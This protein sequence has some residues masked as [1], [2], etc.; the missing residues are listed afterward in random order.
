MPPFNR[1]PDTPVGQKPL[2]FHV[3]NFGGMNQRSGGTRM[4][5]KD[6]QFF[7]QE[8]LWPIQ[9][10]NLESGL[11]DGATVFTTAKTIINAYFYT[12]NL[13]PFCIAFFSDGT[14]T[15]FHTVTGAQ[16]VVS[17][18]ANQF[19]MGSYVPVAVQWN[20]AGIIIAAA[21]IA[22]GYFAWDGTTLFLPGSAAPNWLT[23]TTPTTMP[24]GVR[25]NQIEVYQ[26][27][28][29]L[30]I[31]PVVPPG[32]PTPALIQVSAPSNGADFNVAD[33]SVITPQQDASLRSQ[34]NALK[35]TNGFLYPVGDS[36]LSSISNVQTGGS[37]VITT[38]FN[39]NLSTQEGA[40]WP[41]SAQ[42]FDQALM[43]A[44][45][46][47]VYVVNGGIPIKVSDDIDNLFLNLS[48]STTT[49]SAAIATV[50][51]IKHY[52]LMISTVDFKGVRRNVMVVWNG[53]Q[54][55]VASTLN[56]NTNQIFTQEFNSELTAWGSDGNHMFPLFQVFST[57]LKKQLQ[58]KLYAAGDGDDGWITY[59]KQYRFY[60]EVADLS[61][62]GITLN[63]TMDNELGS[64]PL[65]VSSSLNTFFEFAN[66]SNQIIHFQNVSLVTI[67]WGVQ[68]AGAAING[69][70]VSNYGRLLGWTAEFVGGA[71]SIIAMAAEYTYDAP[72]LG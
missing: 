4:A 53:K 56:A 71:Y 25:G 1:F 13:N 70:D 17:A 52:L 9:N 21:D 65:V 2:L 54:W 14:A 7:W 6:E 36:N 47:G 68:A 61:A 62:Q 69:F 48:A 58:S 5:L 60:W 32:T 66:N 15:Q 16:T 28:V 41:N 27:R 23:N 19:F 8:N 26:N 49:P 55:F 33:G 57:S 11:S 67:V 12:I 31:P 38:Y 42:L 44:N 46:K 59:K 29:W 35:Q 50:F 40:S 3:R 39:Q 34:F 51:Q 22:N 64:T 45:F 10:G 43:Y 72:F 24:S 63:A 37:P 20:A 30:T 18:V